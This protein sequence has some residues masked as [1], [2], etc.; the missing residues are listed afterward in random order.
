MGFPFAT[1]VSNILACMI[2]GLFIHY[3]SQKESNQTFIT[4]FIAIG[5]C[6][7]FSTFSTFSLETVE[8]L[9]NGNYL[10][11][12]TNIASSLICCGIILWILT[13][14]N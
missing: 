10:F 11:G 3:I 1:I 2:L 7:G 9:K 5:F 14:T 12:F 4:S 13:K 8:L 6:G